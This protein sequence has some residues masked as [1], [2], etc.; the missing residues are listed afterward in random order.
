MKYEKGKTIIDRLTGDKITI[1]SSN[2]C[3]YKCCVESKEGIFRFQ[4]FSR[5]QLDRITQLSVEEVH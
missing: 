5:D 1:I 3:N 2:F 4:T